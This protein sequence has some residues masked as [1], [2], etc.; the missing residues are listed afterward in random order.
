MKVT[1]A[2]INRVLTLIGRTDKIVEKAVEEAYAEVG[3]NVVK[4]IRN[5]DL[6]NWQDDSGNL[7]SSIGYVVCRNGR[8]VK[9]S[10]FNTVL[11]GVEGSAKGRKL[12]EQ[13]ASTYSNYDFALIIV[14]GEEYAVYVEAIDNKVVLAGG[15]L[16]VEKNTTKTLQ[17]KINKALGKYEN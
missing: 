15:Q 9:S 7:R 16:F 10:N 12:S 4:G 3:E 14:A 5:G 13:L 1:G 6:S 11:N 8:I 17:E 2:S